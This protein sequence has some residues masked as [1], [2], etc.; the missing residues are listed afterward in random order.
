MRKN[1]EQKIKEYN[2]SDNVKMLG[3][4]ENPYPLMKNSDYFILLS[5]YEGTPV[6]IDECA[7]LKVP[8]IAT[9]VGGVREQM[10]RYGTGEVLELVDDIYEKFLNVITTHREIEKGISIETLNRI[11]KEKIV[12]VLEDR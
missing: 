4:L 8:V 7:V 10:E 9:A 5:T 1:V 12:R 11:N 6:T 3:R 2:L